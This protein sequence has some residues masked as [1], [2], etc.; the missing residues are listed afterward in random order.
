[1]MKRISLFIL[2]LSINCTS[3]K[4]EITPLFYE[5]HHWQEPFDSAIALQAA[6]QGSAVWKDLRVHQFSDLNQ[7]TFEEYYTLHK[8]IYLGDDLS[9]EQN[10]KVYIPVE[11]GNE[12]LD[13]HARC[14]SKNG[15]VKLFDKSNVKELHNVGNVGDVSMFAMEGAEKG[16]FIEYYYTIK[17]SPNFYNVETFQDDVPVNNAELLLIYPAELSFSSLSRNGFASADTE[18]YAPHTI[19]MRAT[20]AHISPLLKEEY[21][22]YRA[23]L[24]AIYYKL[25]KSASPYAAATFDYNYAA[26]R[27]YFATHA[28]EKSDVKRAKKEILPLVAAY[29]KDPDLY[30]NAVIQY[31]SHHFVI[32]NNRGPRYENLSGILQSHIANHFG[33]QRVF[34]LYLK[35]ADI[36][37]EDVYTSDRFDM[38]FD[39]TYE[40]WSFLNEALIYFPASKKYFDPT[41]SDSKY[42]FPPYNLGANYGLFFSRSGNKKLV[43]HGI[44][45]ITLP[46]KN[47]T[48]A[49]IEVHV[50][51]DHNFENSHLEIEKLYS[52]Y[53][54]AEMRSYYEQIANQED[55]NRLSEA[56]LKYITP[57]AN[58]LRYE[59]VNEYDSALTALPLLLKGSEDLSSLVDKAG[60]RYL[61]KI[62]ELLGE[63]N[64]LYKESKRTQPVDFRYPMIYKRKIIVNIPEGYFVRN[65][66]DLSFNISDRPGDAAGCGFVSTYSMN[67]QVLQLNIVEFYSQATYPIGDFEKFRQVVN[68]SADFNKVVLILSAK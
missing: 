18:I 43:Q 52:G 34:H 15:A 2:L 26:N 13:L 66:S 64:E 40:S 56:E 4:A 8:M 39:S 47:L 55:K 6:K 28:F 58:L 19:C 41:N 27:F 45:D 57:D 7:S 33:I 16:G 35:A 17:R 60:K 12:L 23:N 65:L 68:A 59:L 1:M 14:I 44:R 29:D 3:L 37:Y 62:G 5:Q 49:N 10:N 67:G 50:D 20:Q 51:F 61:L 46:D 11:D 9:V 24:Q 42:G 32:V 30:I 25:E 36:D 63:Q 38:R 53:R 54:A 31:V 22:A 48:E 21:G